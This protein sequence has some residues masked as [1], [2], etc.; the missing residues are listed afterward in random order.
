[1]THAQ[2]LRI[3]A[4]AG[5]LVRDLSD[6]ERA[7]FEEHFFQCRPCAAAVRI[8]ESFSANLRA[9]L[10]A[11]RFEPD[12]AFLEMHPFEVVVAGAFC[13]AFSNATTA[14]ETAWHQALRLRL[15]LQHE[16]GIP[17]VDYFVRDRRTGK[18]TIGRET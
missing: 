5:F 17:E 12:A 6:A 16:G 11:K 3:G 7:A 15:K 2:A 8:G 18:C 13:G 14:M 10:R 9:V 4:A 1:M